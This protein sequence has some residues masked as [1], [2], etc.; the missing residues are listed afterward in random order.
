MCFSSLYVDI[1]FGVQS[2]KP[3]HPKINLIILSLES[4]MYGNIVLIKTS[5]KGLSRPLFTSAGEPKPLSKHNI[6]SSGIL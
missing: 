6:Y 1:S 4:S 5:T 3:V 2:S